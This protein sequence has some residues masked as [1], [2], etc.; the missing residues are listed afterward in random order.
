MVE[1]RYLSTTYKYI[2]TSNLVVVQDP[3]LATLGLAS[4]S[5]RLDPNKGSIE[6]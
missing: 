3:Y 2:N 1:M 4:D 5:S 6:P